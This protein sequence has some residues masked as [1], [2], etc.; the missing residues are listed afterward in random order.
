MTI[1]NNLDS[2]KLWELMVLKS[3]IKL[4][5]ILKNDLYRFF[6]EEFSILVLNF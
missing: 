6:Y 1:G 2:S 3:I 5:F 4:S